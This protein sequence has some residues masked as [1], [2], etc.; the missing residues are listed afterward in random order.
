MQNEVF[1][2]GNSDSM[3]EYDGFSDQYLPSSAEQNYYEKHD[4]YCTR[5]IPDYTQIEQEEA[6]YRIQRIAISIM[7]HNFVYLPMMGQPVSLLGFENKVEEI[8]KN[9]LDMINPLIINDDWKNAR[10]VYSDLMTR[11]VDPAYRDQRWSTRFLTRFQDTKN[12]LLSILNNSLFIQQDDW[13]IDWFDPKKILEIVTL[14]L[15]SPS[16]DSNLSMYPSVEECLIQFL[17]GTFAFYEQSV[18]IMQAEIAINIK[19]KHMLKKL[20][21]KTR[22]SV[23]ITLD[24]P[25][26]TLDQNQFYSLVL[27]FLIHRLATCGAEKP[28][29]NAFFDSSVRFDQDMFDRIKAKFAETNHDDFTSVKDIVDFLRGGLNGPSFVFCGYHSQ[30]KMLAYLNDVMP[31]KQN[32]ANSLPTGGESENLNHI[33]N[34]LPTATLP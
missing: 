5:V 14:Q 16:P 33:V 2:M 13:T 32:E 4:H 25:F 18:N 3:P 29:L 6:E 12:W 9:I 31:E 7:T 10:Q 1:F 34:S 22:L 26:N 28:Q 15:V 19:F 21:E 24:E 17:D 8:A 20:P 23:L 30:A 11:F 27:E